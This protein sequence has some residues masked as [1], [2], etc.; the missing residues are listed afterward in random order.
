MRTSAQVF[1][2]SIVAL[3]LA[4]VTGACSRTQDA[5]AQ[6]LPPAANGNL[7]PVDQGQNEVQD[8]TA[9]PQTQQYQSPPVPAGYSTDTQPT[10]AYNTNYNQTPVYATQPPPPLPEYTQP[11][12][13]GDN[14]YWTPG[15]WDY[16]NGGYYWVPGTWVLSPY[17][18]A[19]WTPPYWAFSDGRYT[20]NSGYWGDYI[21]FYGGINYGFGYTGRGYY[22]G[23]WNGNN[24]L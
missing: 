23:Y 14:Y 22:G 18:G 8:Q 17:V 3:G 7:A 9:A 1:G 20:F 16:A 24:F 13:P 11:P 2:C 6:N 4:F 12:C 10:Y 19:L 21:G 15:Y 5:S